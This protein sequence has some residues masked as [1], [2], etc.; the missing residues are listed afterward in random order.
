MAPV[1]IYIG[2][3]LHP[4]GSCNTTTPAYGPYLAV[5]MIEMGLPFST[6]LLCLLSFDIEEILMML[7]EILCAKKASVI[8]GRPYDVTLS[9]RNSQILT[10]LKTNH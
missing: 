4:D 1:Y 2:S 8:L 5:R 10:I 3:S 7:F 6:P 9:I